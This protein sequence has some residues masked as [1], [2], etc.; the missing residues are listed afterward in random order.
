MGKNKV[1]L[2]IGGLDY[3]ITTDEEIA[4]MKNLGDFLRFRR[5]FSAPLTM[6][7]SLNRLKNQTIF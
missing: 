3:Y 4:Y 5:R 1:R 6:P 7:T 2:T